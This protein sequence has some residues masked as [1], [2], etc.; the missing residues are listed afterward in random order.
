M[1]AALPRML[2]SLPDSFLVLVGGGG[3]RP[4]LEQLAHD[5]GVL[6]RTRFLHGLMQEELFA[7]YANC[8]AFAL[9][10]AGEGFGLV[11]LEAMAYGKPVNR[12]IP[13]S[14]GFPR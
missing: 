5:L 3:D 9:P 2:K 12:P 4:R 11:F 6:E 14:T 10:S 1:I 7:C 13:L 8:D